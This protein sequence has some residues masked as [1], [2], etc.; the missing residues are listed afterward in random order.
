MARTPT[1]RKLQLAALV[2]H[3]REKRQ[4]TQHEA[5]REVWP[6]ASAGSVQNKIARLESADTGIT[7][8]DLDALLRLYDTSDVHRRL[9]STLNSDLSQRGRWQGYRSIYSESYRRYVDL[10]EDAELIRYVSNERI[11]ELLQCEA[12]VRAEFVHSTDGIEDLTVRASRARQEG[13]LLRADPPWFYAALSESALRRVQGDE[14]V[15]RKQ[16]EYLVALSERPNITVQVVPFSSRSRPNV[17]THKGILERFALLRLASPGVIGELPRHLD[18]AFTKVGEEL[19]WSDEV[20]HYEDLW[21]RASSAALS[22]HESRAFL[23]EVA[24]DFR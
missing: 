24:R 20:Q 6:H 15:M 19:S 10:E 5:G 3:L 12:Y 16:I 17:I 18:Y 4:L 21:S 14:V 11:P 23:R 1:G 7:P 9:A 8:E 22:P 13:V 2:R